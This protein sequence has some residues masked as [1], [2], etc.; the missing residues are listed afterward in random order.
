MALCLLLLN[1]FNLTHFAFPSVFFGHFEQRHK[2]IKHL[3]KLCLSYR[4]LSADNARNGMFSM[5]TKGYHSQGSAFSDFSFIEF[6]P[7][8]SKY[9]FTVYLISI[10]IH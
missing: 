10:G 6:I 1:N 7:I 3:E 9:S 5:S 4:A 2:N 8:F